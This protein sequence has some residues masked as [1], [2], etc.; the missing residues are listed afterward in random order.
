MAIY[1]IQINDR[2]PLTNEHYMTRITLEP[3][4]K[5]NHTSNNRNPDNQS[6]CTLEDPQSTASATRAAIESDMDLPHLFSARL[7]RSDGGERN[8]L[9]AGWE[10]EQWD[11][12]R[13]L[14]GYG[15][16]NSGP[17]MA[18]FE[19]LIM[20]I[21]TDLPDGNYAIDAAGQIGFTYR[22]MYTLIDYMKDFKATSGTVN[23]KFDRVKDVV[24]ATFQNVIVPIHAFGNPGD[25]PDENYDLKLDG[26]LRIYRGFFGDRPSP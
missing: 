13:Y 5:V 14:F 10:G 23:L 8:F 16:E 24:E 11:T 4:S 2:P 6:E 20:N 9:A 22:L 21:N 26:H 1:S 18:Q 7:M 15:A 12:S 3:F 17:H 19:A 25:G